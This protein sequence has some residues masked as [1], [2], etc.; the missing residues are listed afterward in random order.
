MSLAVIK[1]RLWAAKRFWESS[2]KSQDIQGLPGFLPGVIQGFRETLNII[3][4]Y[5][6]DELKKT[7]TQR[8]PLTRWNG[9]ILYKAC[10]QAYQRLKHSDRLS[11]MRILQRALKRVGKS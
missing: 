11:A 9:L 10:T 2:R 1:Q 5:Q 3:Q 8:H 7:R 4:E 6:R